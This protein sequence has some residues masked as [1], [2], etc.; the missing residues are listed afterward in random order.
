MNLHKKATKAMAGAGIILGIIL[1]MAACSQTNKPASANKASEPA[2]VQLMKDLP[3]P[4]SM[5]VDPSLNAKTAAGSGRTGFR[6][7]QLP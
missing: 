5:T 6:I 7:R 4:K 2:K 3:E 1:T